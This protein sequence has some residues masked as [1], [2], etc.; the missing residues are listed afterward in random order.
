MVGRA[1]RLRRGC[2]REETLGDTIGNP[3][4]WSIDAV[5]GAGKH[6]GSVAGTAGSEDASA[7]PQVRRIST[8]DLR[9]ALR[10]GFDDFVACR[11]DVAF[12]CLLYPIIGI[13]LAYLAFQGSL[14]PLLFPVVSGFALI[15]PVAGVG[16]YEL[17]R[18]REEGLPTSWKDA[19]AVAGSPSFGAILLLALMFGMIFVVWVL[20]A[21]GIYAATLGPERPASIAAFVRDVLTTGPGWA[22]MTIGMATGFLF[23]ALV[24]ATSVVSF[25][26]LLDRRVGLPVAVVTSIRVAE[27]NPGPIAIWGLIVAASL[28]LGSLPVFLGLIVVLP[29]L[30]HATWHLYRR[31]VAWPA[32]REG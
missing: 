30:G 23:A 25:P 22:M 28:A 3:L 32:Q 31:A 17:S 14:L 12:L 15:G 9:D 4:S 18:R 27:R 2:V 19:F 29:V 13:T 8:E 16:L 11:S 26:M 24:L 7:A 6:L 1:A 5:R 10:K 21:N 20:A